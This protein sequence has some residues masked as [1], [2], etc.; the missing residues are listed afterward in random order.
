M[1]YPT[2]SH[3]RPES[4]LD[5]SLSHAS[6]SLISPRLESM[7]MIIIMLPSPIAAVR[8]PNKQLDR[9]NTQQLNCNTNHDRRS[10]GAQRDGTMEPIHDSDAHHDVVDDDRR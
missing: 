5:P 2:G 4:S 10:H 7:M 9:R 6:E 8:D 3:Y 1:M